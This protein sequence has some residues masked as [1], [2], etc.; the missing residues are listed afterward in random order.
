MIDSKAKRLLAAAAAKA[1]FDNPSSGRSHSKGEM[2][3][4]EAI[5]F[6][7]LGTAEVPSRLDALVEHGYLRKRNTGYY[8]YGDHYVDGVDVW[9]ITHKG[10]MFLWA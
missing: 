3:L 10:L 9:A 2:S 5:D 6:S 7:G 1:V 8:G 4:N